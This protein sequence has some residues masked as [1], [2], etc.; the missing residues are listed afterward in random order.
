M[1]LLQRFAAVMSSTNCWNPS[2]TS[3]FGEAGRLKSHLVNVVDNGPGEAPN[4]PLVQMLLIRTKKVLKMESVCQV[5]FSEYHS[6]RNFVERVHAQENKAL[7]RHG[8]FSST[9]VHPKGDPGSSNHRDNME[10]MANEVVKCISTASFGGS[11][12]SCQRGIR[13]DDQIFDDEKEL[14]TFLSLSE[15]R[16]Q[17][18]NKTYKIQKN[19]LSKELCMVWNLNPDFESSYY[20]DYLE[21]L[22]AWKDK[23][24]VFSSTSSQTPSQPIPDY[25]RW[26]NTS[27]LHYLSAED[28][29]S[30]GDGPWARSPSLFMPTRILQLLFETL[31]VPLNGLSEETTLALSILTW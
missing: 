1:N 13:D 20:E 24:T 9:I 27:K 12:V 18:F 23:Y 6:K 8:K 7:S 4:S 17:S 3:C 10:A 19:H 25:V 11:S 5:S 26:L 22:S 31:V 16:K 29:K 30:L 28:T 2:L 14:K 15:S 21:L